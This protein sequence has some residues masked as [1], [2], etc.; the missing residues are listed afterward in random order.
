MVYGAQYGAIRPT[1]MR[2]KKG[3]YAPIVQEQAKQGIATQLVSQS[4]AQQQAKEEQA[5]NQATQTQ[6]LE[7]QR[8]SLDL[9][10]KR[11]KQQK[12]SNYG[13]LAIGAVS[14]G[15]DIIDMFM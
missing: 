2:K 15:L 11:Q 14:T 3:R 12:W 10:K 1:G 5:F 8:R 7:M 4:K 6:Q 13:E 9:E